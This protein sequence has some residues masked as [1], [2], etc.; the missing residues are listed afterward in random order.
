MKNLPKRTDH[1]DSFPSFFNSLW[2]SDFF[3]TGNDMPAVNVKENKRGF[4]LEVSSPGFEKEDFEINVDHNIITISAKKDE[5]YE[6]K[7]SDDRLIRQEFS[8]SSFSRSFTLP[9][10]INTEKISA[11]QKN[12]V[13]I[14]TLPKKE[15]AIEDQVKKI[16][17]K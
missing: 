6:S 15:N 10:N 13:L 9:E 11:T 8:S 2:R 1:F 14:I 4:K 16:E 5:T 7:D 3:S 17:I 12:G